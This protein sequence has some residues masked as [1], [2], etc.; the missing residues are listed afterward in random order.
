MAGQYDMFVDFETLCSIEDKLKM[1]GY[2]LSQ[3]TEQMVTALQYSQEFLSGN[4]FEKAKQTTL[5]CIEITGKTG[6]NITNA[7]AYICRLKEIVDQYSICE[8]NNGEN[9][10]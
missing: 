7:I 1:I 9:G 5:N 6:N 8:Y 10:Q 3:S 4:Q 2:N